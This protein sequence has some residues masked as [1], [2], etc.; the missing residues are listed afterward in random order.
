MSRQVFVRLSVLLA[1]LLLLAACG[2][3]PPRAFP[4]LT[5]SDQPPIGFDVA[6][7]EIVQRYQ[8]ALSEPYVD[9]LFPQRPAAVIRRWAEDRLA[10][11][12]ATGTA[13]LIIQDASVTEEVLARQPGFRGLVTI[14]QSERYEANFTV[15]LEVDD[16]AGRRSGY[17]D[18]EA[19]RDITTPENAS[20]AE[21]EQT[22]FELTEDT[23]RDLDARFDR[24][25][26]QGLAEFIVR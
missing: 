7:I 25:V 13:T 6:R 22:W 16:P 18:V 4:E 11:R 10:A 1:G 3:A 19:R 9:H 15:R 5:F 21:R 26:H 8:P 20:L 14:E 24:E 2:S 12:G 23:I 17:A